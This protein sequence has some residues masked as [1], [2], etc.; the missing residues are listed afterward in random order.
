[1]HPLMKYISWL[2][3]LY[4]VYCGLL[5]FFQ[6][7]ILFPRSLV[8][9]PLKSDQQIAGLQKFWL[10]T[11]FGKVEA[12]FL[13]PTSSL[14]AAPAPAVIF[15]HGNGEIIDFWPA[16]LEGFTRLGIALLLV[17]Y[18]GY[19]SSAGSPSQDS[20]VQTFVAAYDDLV[21]RKDNDSSRIIFFGRSLGGGAVCA[22][23][24]R[25]SPAALILMSTFTSVRSF[26]KQFLLPSFLVRDP[27][28]NLSVIKNYSGPVLILHGR[29]DEVIPF[30]HGQK[31]HKSV[32]NG[33][34]IAY[35]AGHNDCPP[36][37]KIFWRDV[38]GFLHDIGL[39]QSD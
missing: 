31:L 10:N 24:Q 26:A 16:K 7:Q 28:D 19:G 29:S 38:A 32:Q 15:G 25:R 37:W 21:S 9:Q 33:K 1:M 17:E 35:E 30:T 27:F 22:L 8:P 34:M 39:I 36:D 2:L 18:P 12:W 11:G 13:P 5:Y 4:V 23:A 14:P 6:R 3:L 20:I